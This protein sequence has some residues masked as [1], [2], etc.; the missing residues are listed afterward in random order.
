MDKLAEHRSGF[1]IELFEL[2]DTR[3]TGQVPPESGLDWA[4]ANRIFFLLIASGVVPLELV[5]PGHCEMEALHQ[6]FNE[7]Y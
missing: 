2:L 1:S 7:S 3:H 6:H 5:H 4:I